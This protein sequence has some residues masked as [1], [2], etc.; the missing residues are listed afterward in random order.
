[1]RSNKKLFGVLLILALALGASGCKLLNQLEARDHL[2]KGVQA[3]SG[4]RYE[5]AIEEF[6]QAI[7]LDPE[8]VDAHLYLGT[9]HRALFVPFATSPENLRR[10]QEAI[11]TF[12]GVIDIEGADNLRLTT[13]MANIA[14]IYRN[15]NEPERAKDWYRRLMDVLEDKAEALYGIATIDYN[16]ADDLT[17]TDG[18]NVENL[19]EEQVAEVNERVDEAIQSLQEA[20]EIRPSYTDAMEY[21][22]LLYREKAELATE[23]E[24][25]RSWLREADSLA[26]RAVEEKRRQQR[27]EERARRQVFG[28]GAAGETE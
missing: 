14:D 24:E 12:E 10:G 5:E 22:N 23:D 8:L 9:A 1:M 11:A 6:R 25:R 3:Y 16:M 7:E 20:L 21:L 13:A 17:G 26:L 27:E 4:K 19:T 15:M 18:E 28:K 2:N